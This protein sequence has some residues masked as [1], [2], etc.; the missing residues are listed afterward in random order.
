MR[1]PSCGYFES[2]VVDSRPTDDGS[3]IRRRRVCLDCE[4]RF[5]TYERLGENPI[6]VI[7]SDG[8]SEPFDHDKL[9]KGIL[10][11][12]VKRPISS[13]QITAVVDDIENT[14]RQAT[15]NE[16][17]SKE[18]GEMTLS[19]LA[20]LDDVAYV[21]FASVYRDFQNVEEFKHVLNEF[22]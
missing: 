2:K 11:A 16:I 6:V 8:T 3:T 19:R 13:D 12:C 20:Q 15:K 1:C 10:L 7:K 22:N 9:F 18:I 4:Y 17:K 21:R 14:L 5:T